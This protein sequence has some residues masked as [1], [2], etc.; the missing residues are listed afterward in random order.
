MKRAALMIGLMVV[1]RP[2][3][4]ADERDY[5]CPPSTEDCSSFSRHYFIRTLIGFGQAAQV[6][7]DDQWGTWPNSGSTV[8][9]FEWGTFPLNGALGTGFSASATAD[10][11]SQWTVITPGL[12]AKLD[13]TYVFI[14]GLWATRPRA[15][16]PY[17]IQFGGR[18]G[19][20][21]SQSFRPTQDV[22]ETRPYTLLR[23]EVE[24]FFDFEKSLDVDRRDFSF[25]VRPALDTSINLSTVFRWS[26]QVGLSY[27]WDRWDG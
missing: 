1:C 14:S 24:S 20:G 27:A 19:L 11:K 7:A 13:L 3:W 9:T 21:A 25:V 5:S 17:R 12:F 16:F 18:L 6:P 8:L 22:P 4:A 2:S 26:V 10:V 15:D 23:P